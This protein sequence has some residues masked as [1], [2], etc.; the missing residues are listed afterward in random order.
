[1]IVDSHWFLFT[2][3]EFSRLMKGIYFLRVKMYSSSVEL[4]EYLNGMLNLVNFSFRWL[5]YHLTL[6]LSDLSLR[7][8]MI[9]KARHHFSLVFTTTMSH[10]MKA[11]PFVKVYSTTVKWQ[12][13]K[14]MP[15]HF[16]H[17]FFDFHRHSVSLRSIIN[18][19]QSLLGGLHTIWAYMDG[20][21]FAKR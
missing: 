3:C 19:C 16:I 5:V 15:L 9:G 17:N 11:M 6:T 20:S 12:W 2:K 8:E 13:L 14:K 21:E 1:M 10:W 18:I 7:L 4:M